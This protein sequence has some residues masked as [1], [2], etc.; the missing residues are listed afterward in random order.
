MNISCKKTKSGTLLRLEGDFTIYNVAQAKQEFFNDYD[1]FVSPISLDL[2]SVSEIDSAGL[3]LLLFLQKMLSK[4]NKKIYIE[5]SNEHVD[6][7]LKNL[8]VTTY[9]ALDN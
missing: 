4:D 7:I 8:D 2:N 1:S 9:F 3:Q 5:K 6:A